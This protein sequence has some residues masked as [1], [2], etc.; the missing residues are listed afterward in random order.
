MLRE[1]YKL[2]E[3]ELI[4][5]FLADCFTRIITKEFRLKTLAVL[6]LGANY[7]HSDPD[8]I[9]PKVM[10]ANVLHAYFH[11]SEAFAEKDQSRGSAADAGEKSQLRSRYTIKS[12]E[13]VPKQEDSQFMSDLDILNELSDKLPPQPALVPHRVLTHQ[14]RQKPDSNNRPAEPFFRGI[15][16]SRFFQSQGSSQRDKHSPIIE[17]SQPLH[18]NILVQPP[19][20]KPQPKVPL[21]AKEDSHDSSAAREIKFRMPRTAEANVFQVEEVR[22]RQLEQQKQQQLE[23]VMKK[24]RELD[25]EAKQDFREMKEYLINIKTKLKD[26][27]QEAD[28]TRAVGKVVRGKVGSFD[29][30]ISN[31][32]P[33]G[34]QRAGQRRA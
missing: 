11:Q 20:S 3:I 30:G 8:D 28:L 9:F 17:I 23:N 34:R 29:R 25:L 32:R 24:K 21:E 27:K 16:D 6:V 18:E 2:H 4:S 7:K 15:E 22:H 13:P 26:L 10:R 33:V 5:G 31:P 19:F 14:V 12:Q 1:N